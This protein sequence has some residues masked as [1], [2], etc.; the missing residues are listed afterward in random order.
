MEPY[1]VQDKVEMPK[2]R[3]TAEQLGDYINQCKAK[4]GAVTINLGIYQDGTVD[5]NAVDVLKE[6]RKRV[7]AVNS[8]EKKR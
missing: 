2:P 8:V 1:W 6:L 5:P 7:I 4:G 3:F